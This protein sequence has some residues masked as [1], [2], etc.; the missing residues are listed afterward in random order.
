V[1]V[2]DFCRVTGVEQPTVEALL[3]TG[4]LDGVYRDGQPYALFDD[5]LP[6][7]RQLQDLGLTVNS[8]YRPD[9][10]RLHQEDDDDADGVRNEGPNWTMT[11]EDSGS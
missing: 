4:R 11:S 1:L 8:D 3:A 9:D 6:T 5:A 10:M 7:V 2:T